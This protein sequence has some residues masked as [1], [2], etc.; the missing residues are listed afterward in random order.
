MAVTVIIT[1]PD[2]NV[3]TDPRQVKITRND[4]PEFYRILERYKPKNKIQ[5]EETG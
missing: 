3:Y 2:G 5:E 1:A 4:F